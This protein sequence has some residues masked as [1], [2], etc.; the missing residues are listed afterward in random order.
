[1]P[2]L[3]DTPGCDWRLNCYVSFEIIEWDAQLMTATGWHPDMDA[4]PTPSDVLSMVEVLEAQHGALAEDIAEFFATK[5][6]LAGDA[7]RSWA[8]AGVAA[9][10]RQRTKKRL[11]EKQQAA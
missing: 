3:S 8:W 10:L 1:E 7:G 9:R 5:H 6:C 4:T 11:L 2:L